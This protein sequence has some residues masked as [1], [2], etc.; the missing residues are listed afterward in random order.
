MRAWLPAGPGRRESPGAAPPSRL[1]CRDYRWHKSIVIL[2]RKDARKVEEQVRQQVFEVRGIVRKEIENKITN[3]I[4]NEV[5]SRVGE[6]FYE[7]ILY[8][9]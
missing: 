2:T 4:Y 9:H 8:S 6:K 5:S 1:R 3:Q 7:I